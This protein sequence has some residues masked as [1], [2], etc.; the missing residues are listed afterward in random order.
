MSEEASQFDRALYRV[1]MSYRF[2]SRILPRRVW[3]RAGKCLGLLSYLADSRH[4]KII[5]TNLRLAFGTEKEEKDIR[6]LTRRIYMQFGMI[7][8][9]WMQLK[10]ISPGELSELV[11]VEGREHLVSAKKKSKSVI[12]LSAHFGNWE[13]A[14]LFYASTINKLTFIVRKIDNP[15]LEKERIAYN[16]RAGVNI[17]YK[18]NGL[19]EAIRNL[20]RGRD[21]VIFADQNV[22][23]REG[24]PCYFFGKKAS[25]ISLV[26]ALA[27]KFQVPVVPMFMVRS[28]D[29]LHHR[30]LFL[31]ELD[32]GPDMSEEGIQKST[33]RMNDAI[34]KVVRSY[35]D[36]WLWFHRK[37]KC[38]YPEIYQF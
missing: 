16:Q 31:P 15:L 14:H 26:P 11:H 17:V 10:D 18:E 21:L 5:S 37:W 3:L 2:L 22:N 28:Q 29:M 19:R 6:S 32:F 30:I 12:L 34:E 38:Y 20:K 23:M 7:G 13:Y 25:T 33:Q 36:H 24:I 1:V 4:R 35:P 8:H 9:E 27:K